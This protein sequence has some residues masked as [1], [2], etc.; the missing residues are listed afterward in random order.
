[1]NLRYFAKKDQKTI[2][3]HRREIERIDGKLKEYMSR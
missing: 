2:E 1:M 3:A